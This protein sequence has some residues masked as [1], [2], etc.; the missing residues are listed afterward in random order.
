MQGVRKQGW[1][2]TAVLNCSKELSCHASM[3]SGHWTWA[4]PTK[5]DVTL[6]QGLFL[7]LRASASSPLTAGERSH[8]PRMGLILALPCCY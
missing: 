6:S 3:L 7:Q 4:A 8:S 2:F 1:S 5:A